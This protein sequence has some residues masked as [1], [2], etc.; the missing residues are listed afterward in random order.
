MR[1]SV[2]RTCHEF[3]EKMLLDNGTQDRRERDRRD[4]RS[5]AEFRGTLFQVVRRVIVVHRTGELADLLAPDL[6]VTRHSIGVPDQCRN[7]VAHS[8]FG[9][10]KARLNCMTSM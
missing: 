5:I 10:H 7:L 4:Q 3:G 8:Q 1:W 2:C 9:C 6:V